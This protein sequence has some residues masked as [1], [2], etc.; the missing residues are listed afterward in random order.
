MKTP[1]GDDAY[2]WNPSFQQL[3]LILR[4]IRRLVTSDTVCALHLASPPTATE[5]AQPVSDNFDVQRALVEL[6]TDAASRSFGSVVRIIDEIFSTVAFASL[7]ISEKPVSP[8]KDAYYRRQ[9]KTLDNPAGGEKLN[10]HFKLLT[11]K[12]S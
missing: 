5:S 1:F 6:R 8:Q 7:A 2:R 12:N 9:Q 4:I 11:P 10:H 3:R